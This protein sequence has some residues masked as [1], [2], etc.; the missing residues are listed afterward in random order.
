M[1]EIYLYVQNNLDHAP[2]IVFG[3]FVLAGFNIPI[4][5]D[6]LLFLCGILASKN[7]DHLVPLFLS[8]YLGAYVSDVMCYC[9]WRFFGF[10]LFHL[11][12]FKKAISPER[13]EKL[14]SFYH[15]NGLI[16]LVI[17]RFIPFG[18]RNALFITIGA[19][20]VSFFKFALYDFIAAT[21]SCTSFFILYY[22]F[23]ES[24]VT[25]IKKGNLLLI[26]LVALGIIG[27]FLKK[28]FFQKKK[29]KEGKSLPF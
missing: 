25:Y 7:P 3:L 24:V 16:T 27:Y 23:G 22:S 2:Y 4:S 17:G 26:S 6:A 28:K 18:F 8:V 1:E 20:K 9:L 19:S 15:R 13:M 12:Y 14:R 29:E 21:I 5:E 10:K 11:P